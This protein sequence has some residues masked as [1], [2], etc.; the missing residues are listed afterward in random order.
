M[1]ALSYAFARSG[2]RKPFQARSIE[3]DASARLLLAKTAETVC[4]AVSAAQSELAPYLVPV[5][6]YMTALAEK[7]GAGR[8]LSAQPLLMASKIRT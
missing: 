2:L 3:S 6:S 1:F 5:R 7:A 4:E 8:H